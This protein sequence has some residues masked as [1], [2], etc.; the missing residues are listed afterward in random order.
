MTTETDNELFA[1]IET[2]EVDPP[3]GPTPEEIQEREFESGV[4][5]VLG[6]TDDT[7]QESRPA[8]IAGMSEEELKT[9]LNKA[10]RVDDLEERLGKL[11]DK[12]FG[13]IGQMKQTIDEL[14]SRPQGGKPNISKET[15]KALSEYFDDENVAEALAKDFGGLEFQGGSDAVSEERLSQLE[16]KFELRLLD[17][18][19]K[20][21]REQYNSPEFPEWKATL[22]P[23]AQ[24]ILDNSWDGAAMAEA[25]TTFKKWK[26]KRGEA[27]QEKQK[28]L[29]SAVTPG[30][31]GRSAGAVSDDAFNQGLKKVV[32]QRLR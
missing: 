2:P 3:P 15:F 12:A 10:A 7:T 17:F 21:W 8:L 1:S 20:D 5:G 24:E 27:E 22:K 14:R 13:T 31:S 23:E 9:L 30:S 19:H 25:I 4:A 11:Q 28:R 16:Q 18:A 29:E 32:S 26:A 6:E